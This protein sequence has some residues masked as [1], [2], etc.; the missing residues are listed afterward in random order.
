MT[1]VC[2]SHKQE[3]DRPDER[4]PGAVQAAVDQSEREARQER[5]DQRIGAADNYHGEGPPQKPVAQE[6]RDRHQRG[7]DRARQAREA[8]ADP[9]G[10]KI[11]ARRVG[12]ERF[13]HLPVLH[14]GAHAEAEIGMTEE[15]VDRGKDEH[16]QSRNHDVV[17]GI[18]N[19]ADREGAEGRRHARLARSGDDEDCLDYDHVDRPSSEQAI[20]DAAV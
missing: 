18:R 17:S 15:Q 3:P 14:R 6:G 16:G 7:V 13:R 11:D 4:P 8:G 1:P 19:A 2:Q 10:Q 12:A 9:K 5:A 20:E